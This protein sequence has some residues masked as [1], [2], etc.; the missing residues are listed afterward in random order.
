MGYM[1]ILGGS[2]SLS[3]LE[4]LVERSGALAG[5]CF[6]TICKFSTQTRI[7]APKSRRQDFFP[8]HDGGRVYFSCN[9]S[10]VFTLHARQHTHLARLRLPH[11]AAQARPISTF[12]DSISV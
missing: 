6:C 10:Q 12:L 7:H 3:L 2:N 8:P 4:R 11:K 5:L 1:I 9:V